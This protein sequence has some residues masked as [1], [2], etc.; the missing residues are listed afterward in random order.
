MATVEITEDAFDEKVLGSDRPVLVDFWAA[1]CAP[2]RA[3]APVLEELSET[4]SDH[5][6]IA[7][8]DVDRAP[9]LSERY[10]I[11]SIPTMILFADGKPLQG[12]QGALPKQALQQFIEQYVPGLA[13]AT[14]DVMALNERLN[15]PGST[16][17]Y[18]VRA[19]ADYKRSHIRGSKVVLPDDLATEVDAQP[20]NVIVVLVDRS[21]DGAADRV[22]EL[23]RPNVVALQGGLL[24]WEGAGLPTY[25]SEEE[26]KLEA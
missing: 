22:K 21:G 5:L 20:S 23:G 25:S 12:V 2:C 26:A 15:I 1:W 8:V 19:E 16:V 10:R 4:Y 24:E 3:V 6:T 17:V 18:D 11:R 9:L 14:I 13:P 7:K